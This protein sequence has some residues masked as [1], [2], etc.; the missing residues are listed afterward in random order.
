MGDLRWH[1]E[2]SHLAL[3][4]DST[5]SMPCFGLRDIFDFKTQTVERHPLAVH[6][7]RNAELIA[8]P[9]PTLRNARAWVDPVAA[10]R[11]GRAGKRIVP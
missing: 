5:L 11:H 7:R 2:P 1:H 10:A 4:G 3:R 9:V 8:K 6:I